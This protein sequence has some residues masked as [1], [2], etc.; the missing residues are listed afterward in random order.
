VGATVAIV[1]G[2]G[3]AAALLGSATT[4]ASGHIQ[5]TALTTIKV[6]AGKPSEFRFKL[7]KV[8]GIPA[9][10][11][12]FK[13]TNAGKIPHN[14]KVCTRPVTSTKANACVGKSTPTI[15]PGKTVSLTV[16]LKKGK[17]EYLCTVSGHAA[18]GMKGLVGVAVKVVPPPPTPTTT[19][20]EPLLGDPVAGAAVWQA[21]PCSS[22]HTMAKA[23]ATGSQC[24][25]LDSVKPTQSIV[26]FYVQ[27]GATAGGTTMPAFTNMSQTDLNNLAAYVY[28]ST[29]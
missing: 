26:K 28:Q 11:V 22:C 23:G 20:P 19:G 27:N 2:V 15:K 9:G 24:P 4:P 29:H 8:S 5:K 18:L 6:T 10:K 16:T 25:N 7:S 17:F 14:F 3:F 21:Q 12:V 1:G 13:F